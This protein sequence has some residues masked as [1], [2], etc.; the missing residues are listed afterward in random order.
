MASRVSALRDRIQA[1]VARAPAG[2]ADGAAGPDVVS[3][4][5]EDQR[6]IVEQAQPYTMT[7]PERIVAAIDAVEYVTRRGVPGAIAECGVWRGGSVLAMVLALQRLGVDDRD[8]YLFD[9]FEGMAAPTDADTSP[10]DEPAVASWARARASGKRLWDWWFDPKDVGVDSVRRL[11]QATGYPP[12][13][14][15]FVVGK[16]EDTVPDEAPTEFAILRLDTDWYESTRHELIHLYPRLSSGGVLIV[17]DYGHWDGCRM[18]VD[19]YFGGTVPAVYFSRI[20]YS[21]RVAI[22]S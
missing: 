3:T 7:G 16:V 1:R 5:T 8:I 10:Y 9:T 15:H 20:D 17:D 6:A 11:L 18:A 13:H 21:A 14:L 2:G 4:L 12:E 22:K 19:E